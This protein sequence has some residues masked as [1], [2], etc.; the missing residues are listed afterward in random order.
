MI[1]EAASPRSGRQHGQVFGEGHLSDL[2][3]TAVLLHLHSRQSAGVPYSSYKDTKPIMGAPSHLM[4]SS[5]SN[6]LPKA[7]HPNIMTLGNK[8]SKCESGVTQICSL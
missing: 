7:L 2:K 1:L 3:V 4:T 5:K 6:H 8:I